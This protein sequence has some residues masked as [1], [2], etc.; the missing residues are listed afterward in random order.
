MTPQGTPLIERYRPPGP[1]ADA[2]V[3]SPARVKLIMGPYGSG[4]TTTCF[5][6]CTRIAARVPRNRYDGVR[7]AVG[8]VVRDTY[9][10]LERNTI[11]SWSEFV[12]PVK[13]KGFKGGSGGEPGR[14][15]FEMEVIANGPDGPQVDR[16]HL[17]MLFVAIGEHAVREFM[18]GFQPS[19]VF[20]NG[21][22]ALPRD[23][24]MYANGRTGRWPRR[25]DMEDWLRDDDAAMEIEAAKYKRIIADCNAPD[26]DN[27]VY[28]DFVEAPKEGFA[29]FRQPG[30]LEPDA[31]NKHNLVAGYYE[32]MSASAEEWWIRRYVDN[33]F[34]YS[35]AGEPVHPRFDDTK[36]VTRM[37]LPID[38]RRPLIIGMDT[39]RSPAAVLLQKNSHHQIRALGEVVPPGKEG[40][41]QFGRRLREY[42]AERCPDHED[43]IGVADPAGDNDSAIDDNM[44][45]IE[46]VANVAGI[47]VE[48]AET[49]DWTPRFEALNKPI[50]ENADNGQP[51]FIVSGPDCPKL[52]RALMSGY[53]YPRKKVNDPETKPRPEKNWHSHV[54]EGCH[55]GCMKLSDMHELL[56]RDR[57]RSRHT[58]EEVSYDPLADV[59]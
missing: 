38:P 11:P 3:R 24:I 7:Y 22:D 39:D 23:I 31:E 41:R 26:L 33:R 1:V 47:D 4:K 44:S 9:R 57:R 6:E 30:G 40:A 34:G 37:S 13:Q 14:H 43:I 52:T 46:T 42:I 21:V 10:N 18:D 16:V 56:G 55:Y 49:N 20:L 54:A 8:L 5:H 59:A 50:T 19:F 27:W 17:T 51:G 35:R 15:E 58:R 12:G 2:F 53:R 29:F 28:T 25:N 32:D 48:P 45:W 36:H